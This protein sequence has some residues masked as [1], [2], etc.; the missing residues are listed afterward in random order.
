MVSIRNK[1]G[2]YHKVNYVWEMNPYCQPD[3]TKSIKTKV[4]MIS[5]TTHKFEKKF[6][7]FL[8]TWFVKVFGADICKEINHNVYFCK[9][10]ERLGK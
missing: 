2:Y 1:C 5:L 4:E 10:D 9:N 3:N 6:C 8:G 7:Q